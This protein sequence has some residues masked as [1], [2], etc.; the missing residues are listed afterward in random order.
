M[1]CILKTNES[2]KKDCTSIFLRDYFFNIDLILTCNWY[3]TS[4]YIMVDNLD[5]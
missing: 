5:Q 2:L 4:I 1:I 3:V